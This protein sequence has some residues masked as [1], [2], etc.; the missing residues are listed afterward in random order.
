M[1][2]I[3]SLFNREVNDNRLYGCA[4]HVVT[5]NKHRFHNSFIEFPRWEDT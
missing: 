5:F 3:G 2:H 4:S 1:Y